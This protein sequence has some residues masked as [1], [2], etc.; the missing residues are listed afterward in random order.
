[1]TTG[2]TKRLQEPSPRFNA[3][4]AGCL[5]LLI[6]LGG[7]FAPFAVAPSGMMLGDAALP[8]VAK[9]LGEEK[10]YIMGGVVQLLVYTCDIGVALIFYEILKPVHRNLALVAAWFRLIFVAIASANILNH[11]AP[12][13]LLK[14]AQYQSA[15][16]P[17]QLQALALIFIR[18]RTYGFDIALVF[19]GFHC[20][21]AGYLFFKS[22]FFPRVL[23]LALA[24]GGMGYIANITATAIPSTIATH[25]F[26]YV[27]LPAGVAEILLTLW[28][29]VVGVNVPKWQAQA[30]LAGM[31]A[32]KNGHTVSTT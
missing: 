28:L 4:F 3:R 15:L 9:I 31:S 14:G 29:I 6:I 11:F 18:L 20:L 22:T 8:T 1:M 27:M 25:L 16:S 21:F 5:Y 24:I 19:F 26:P 10:L 2:T 23:G 17:G 30:S 32:P 7:L 12:A 13:I